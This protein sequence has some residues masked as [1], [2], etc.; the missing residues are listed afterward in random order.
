VDSQSRRW[1]CSAAGPH[2]AAR[3]DAQRRDLVYELGSALDDYLR[4][5][6]AKLP[7]AN[8]EYGK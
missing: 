3:P 8:P 5:I 1:H 7:T 4:R 6:E 2:E